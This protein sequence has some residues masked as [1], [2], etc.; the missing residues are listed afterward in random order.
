MQSFLIRP[1]T[2]A[3]DP[4]IRQI[5]NVPIPGIISLSLQREPNFFIGAAIQSKQTEVYVIE[6][7][8]EIVGLF[9]IGQKELYWQGKAQT[10][11]YY[12]DLRIAPNFRHPWNVS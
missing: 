8:A 7:E 4:A 1:A 3:D 2:P 11:R 6:K 9:S 12:A 10:F 5:V